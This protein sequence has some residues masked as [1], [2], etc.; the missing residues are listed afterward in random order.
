MAAARKTSGQLRGVR[1]MG[2]QLTSLGD[3]GGGTTEISGSSERNVGD[4]CEERVDIVLQ[5]LGGEV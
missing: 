2:K 3:P 4:G 5:R 1:R